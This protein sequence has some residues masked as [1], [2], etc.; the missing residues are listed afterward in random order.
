MRG[1]ISR[2]PTQLEAGRR[3]ELH[4]WLWCA[5]AVVFVAVTVLV[6]FYGC[7]GG[8]RPRP[9]PGPTTFQ[10]TDGLR[11]FTQNNP[12]A[13]AGFNNGSQA[14]RLVN[15]YLNQDLAQN[16][17]QS[18]YDA[19]TTAVNRLGR[20]DQLRNIL[21]QYPNLR[22]A[23]QFSDR[24]NDG[25][26]DDSDRD[27]WADDLTVDFDVLSPDDEGIIIG[28]LPMD[29]KFVPVSWR[30]LKLFKGR[31]KITDPN[32]N[33]ANQ[34]QQEVKVECD[35]SKPVEITSPEPN[36][37]KLKLLGAFKER[38]PRSVQ[39]GQ[40][41]VQAAVDFDGFTI[42]DTQ[43]RDKV[44][45]GDPQKQEW[46]PV[47]LSIDDPA[48]PWDWDFDA[49]DW[50][51]VSL[52]WFDDDMLGL[53]SEALMGL[54]WTLDSKGFS[55]FAFDDCLVPIGADWEFGFVPR[56]RR[57]AEL[58]DF[59]A[60]T[61]NW[62]DAGASC[63]AL[64]FDVVLPA[65]NILLDELP[66]EDWS[67]W[68]E[69][70]DSELDTYLA[71][72]LNLPP[73]AELADA[74]L[75]GEA[76]TTGLPQFMHDF[77][78]E[79]HSTLALPTRPE[80]VEVDGDYPS[81]YTA[82]FSGQTVE[83]L[84]ESYTFSGQVAFQ[85][86]TSPQQMQISAT[87]T[88]FQVE[89]FDATLNG[90]LAMT[91]VEGEPLAVNITATNFRWEISEVQKG[92]VNG[93]MQASLTLG[94]NGVVAQVITSQM[95]LTLSV[96][97]LLITPPQTYSATLTAVRPLR[98]PVTECQFS[99]EG[100]MGV[101]GTIANQQVNIQIDFGADGAC[102]KAEITSAGKSA[103]YNLETG[104]FEELTRLKGR[105]RVIPLPERKSIRFSRR[106]GIAL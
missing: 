56:S 23:L 93:T 105:L 34:P 16:I 82:T 74:I 64:N 95:N 10:G 22:N 87:F 81:N 47:M 103:I 91:L 9:S 31:C 11:R 55:E 6:A 28:T 79:L 46:S 38:V 24:D 15:R 20:T 5:P 73:G 96:T 54:Y 37:P 51:D 84:G 98:W 61:F 27:N 102:E 13:A 29:K 17:R 100:V 86:Q 21:Q 4:R 19:L 72:L 32:L 62:A 106:A 1:R 2:K 40:Q 78:L 68:V 75:T 90:T 42:E 26:P 7:G 97:N 33:D 88:N 63:D 41:K 60:F 12:N 67:G 65:L 99:V 52:A 48:D 36:R 43:T 44:K 70:T 76:F 53:A 71:S 50:D 35:A 89:E 104:L 8:G 59:F 58:A 94:Q 45:L 3:R 83:L 25:F 69:E 18:P 77:V 39:Q 30:G 85:F 66:E 57:Q 101:Q 49:I 14:S 80:G 92:S